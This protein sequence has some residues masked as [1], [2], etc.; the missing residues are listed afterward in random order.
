M[1]DTR[2]EETPIPRQLRPGEDGNARRSPLSR[3]V[4]LMIAVIVPVSAVVTIH[5]WAPSRD[6]RAWIRKGSWYAP[7]PDGFYGADKPDTRWLDEDEWRE[8]PVAKMP[9]ATRLLKKV[10]CVQLSAKQAVQLLG[11]MDWSKDKSDRTSFLV[12]GV[13]L[14]RDSGGF[15]V[16]RGRDYLS[17]NHGCMGASPVP[18]KR[19]ALVLLLKKKPEKIYVTCGMTE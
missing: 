16:S 12:R 1:N 9:A 13:L 18:M 10:P 7:P 15:S 5:N 14:N 17:V 3:A 8:V 6:S 4:W 19:Q 2:S 11:S